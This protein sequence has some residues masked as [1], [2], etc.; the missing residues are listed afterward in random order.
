MRDDV[1]D[2]DAA[3]IDSG[4]DERLIQQLASRPDERT[5]LDV[6]AIT[7]LLSHQH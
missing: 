4:L 3:A 1:G 2:V 6:L 5:T 7:G